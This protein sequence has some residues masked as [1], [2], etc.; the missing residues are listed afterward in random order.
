MS[1][2]LCFPLMAATEGSIDAD[3]RACACV[4]DGVDAGA[5][6]GKDEEWCSSFVFS[7]CL[8]DSAATLRPPP[9]GAVAG[10]NRRSHP[11]CLS[12]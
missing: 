1:L 7:L 10:V 4:H 9:G 2:N 6:V 3:G 11:L 8:V 5:S 12:A